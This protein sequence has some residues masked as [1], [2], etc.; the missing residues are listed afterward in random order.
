MFRCLDMG[1]DIFIVTF[2]SFKFSAS[3]SSKSICVKYDTL[4]T[5]INILFSCFFYIFSEEIK[6][7]TPLY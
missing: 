3:L 4:H 5:L 1:L 7:R 6:R 2:A